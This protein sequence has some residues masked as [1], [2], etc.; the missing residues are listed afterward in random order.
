MN[1][2]T[3]DKGWQQLQTHIEGFF[4]RALR[5]DLQRIEYKPRFM[6]QLL[7]MPSE[8]QQNQFLGTM[9]ISDNLSQ[10]E[11]EHA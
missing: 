10:K 11:D 2:Q 9:T 4:G 6:T 7:G 5:N 8:H 3:S 1:Q